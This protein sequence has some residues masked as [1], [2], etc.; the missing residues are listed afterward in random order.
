MG[1]IFSSDKQYKK[2]IQELTLT[3]KDQSDLIQQQH[4]QIRTLKQDISKLLVENESELNEL[5]NEI[6]ALKTNQS[7]NEQRRTTCL[8]KIKKIIISELGEGELPAHPAR[9]LS[10]S[11]H[12]E[13]P[14]VS[15]KSFS[16]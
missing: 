13:E 4:K 8:E 6:Q 5:E 15:Q 10:Q 12:L 2:K 3:A 7:I 14:A 11:R 1:I 16:T 9:S